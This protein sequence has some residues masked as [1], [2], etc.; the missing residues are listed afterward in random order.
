[1]DRRRFI[2][3][4]LAAGVA[5][6]MVPGFGC[7]PSGLPRR[8]LGQTGES[9]S[10]IGF[11]GMVARS[12]TP[13]HA[14][15]LVERAIGQGINYFDVAPTYGQSEKV[16]GP[17]LEPYRDRIFLASKTT[18]RHAHGAQQE[19][20]T[21]LSRL[22]TDHLDLYQLHAIKSLEDVET[23]FG[24]GGAME[25]FLKARDEGKA[26]YLGFTAHGVE[27]A[28]AA[29]DRFDFDTVMFPVNYTMWTRGNFGP[30]VVDRA[31]GKGMGVLAIKA[32]CRGPWPEGEERTHDCWYQPLADPH[33]TR[34]AL[35]FAMSQQVTAALPPADE[36]LFWSTL[37]LVPGLEPFSADDE[38]V[39]ESIADQAAPLFQYSG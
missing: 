24:P 3:T 1:M 29:M 21:S 15:E 31:H 19:L 39:L 35:S 27:A 36:E 8:P 2:K 16:L 23:I 34:P 38:R 18:E 30:Q 37:E 13:E 28:M 20:S 26:R 9:L 5:G 33:E 10:V 11:G 14:G 32:T 6:G 17:A 25:V 12:A 22:R 4:T 7:S